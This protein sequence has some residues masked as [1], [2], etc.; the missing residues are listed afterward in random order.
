M[1]GQANWVMAIVI[2]A[3]LVGIALLVA[4]S[5]QVF[6]RFKSRPVVV[7]CPATGVRTE[8][9]VETDF[10]KDGE[11][12]VVCC[13]RFEDPDDVRCAQACLAQ[14]DRRKK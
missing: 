4:Y 9:L 6:E 7:T 13:A 11:H 12:R 10:A 1:D 8:I 3:G 14:V 5:K 2:A